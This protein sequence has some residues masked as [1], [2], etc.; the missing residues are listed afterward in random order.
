[1][2]VDYCKSNL[3]RDI[4]MGYIFIKELKTNLSAIRY[5]I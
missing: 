1:M 3:H 5:N 4:L 2:S